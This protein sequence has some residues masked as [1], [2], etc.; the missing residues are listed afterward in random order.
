[1]EERRRDFVAPIFAKG[2]LDDIGKGIAIQDRADGIPNVEH[3]DSQ[4]TVNFIRARAASVGCLADAPNRRQ[5]AI[6]Q[7][8]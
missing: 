8:E 4:A 3:Q 5:W 6:D 1:M 7:A 2:D